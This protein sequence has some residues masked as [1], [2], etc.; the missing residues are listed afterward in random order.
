MLVV[1]RPS[2][3]ARQGDGFFFSESTLFATVIRYENSRSALSYL[4]M[5]VY[6]VAGTLAAALRGKRSR[7]GRKATSRATF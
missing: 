6:L 2:G 3:G 1:W 4:D 7:D 5:I